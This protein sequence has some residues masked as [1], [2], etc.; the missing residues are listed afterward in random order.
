MNHVL[1]DAPID[2]EKNLETYINSKLPLS[3]VFKENLI[4]FIEDTFKL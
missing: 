2:R 1:K 4:E 3:S